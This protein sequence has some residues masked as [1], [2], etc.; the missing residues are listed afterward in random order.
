MQ[1]QQASGLSASAFCR[2]AGVRGSLFFK[3]R[4]KLSALPAG[5]AEVKV[6][7]MAAAAGDAGVVGESGLIELRWPGRRSVVV[8][9]G[10]DRQ[11]LVA[12][13]DIVEA[14]WADRAALARPE[15]GR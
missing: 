12:L 10:F 1:E 9:P 14:C 11:T 2:Q 3:W 7:T 4:Q 13:L 8:R 6:P 5:F 15:V